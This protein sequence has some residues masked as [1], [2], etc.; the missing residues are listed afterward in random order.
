MST[1]SEEAK[2]YEVPETFNITDLREV[3]IGNEINEET[4]TD[5]EGKAFKVK[6]I[7]IEGKKYRVPLVV[8]GQLKAILE[9]MPD[10]KLFCVTKEGTGLNT[11]YTTIPL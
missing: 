6:Y 7:V 5:K 1:I 3:E 9:K 8:L 11:R 4:A 2:A 10:L